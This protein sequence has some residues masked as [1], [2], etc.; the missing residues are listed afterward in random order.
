VG[1]L[2][3]GVAHDFNNLLTVVIGALDL[4]QRHPSDAARR[5]R[6]IE[7]ALGAAR[8]GERLTQQLAGLSR[9]ARP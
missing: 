2:T 9:G 8:R 4:M 7:A 3:G 1:Q 5:E 6:M